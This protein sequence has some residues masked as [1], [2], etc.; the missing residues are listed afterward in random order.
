MDAIWFGDIGIVLVEDDVGNKKSYIG[1]GKGM[2][3]EEDIDY[4]TKF[5]KKFTLPQSFT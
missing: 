3:E 5:G 1:V 4:I 2:N